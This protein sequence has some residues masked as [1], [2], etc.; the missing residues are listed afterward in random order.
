MNNS[1]DYNTNGS[2]IRNRIDY[3][4]DWE[5]GEVPDERECEDQSEMSSR[6]QR[7]NNEGNMSNKD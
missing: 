4:E 7:K 3:E 6:S 2:L 1:E 5:L